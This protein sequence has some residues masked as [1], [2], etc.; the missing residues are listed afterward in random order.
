MAITRERKGEKSSPTWEMNRLSEGYK[1]AI[2]QN[3][4]RMA[5]YNHVL[6]TTGKSCSTKKVAFAQMIITQNI[7]FGDF[8]G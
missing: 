5:K 4:N 8:L 1:Q 2:D 3:W 6:A 7:I